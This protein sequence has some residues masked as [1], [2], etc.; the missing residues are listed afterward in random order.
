M[1]TS[2]HNPKRPKGSGTRPLVAFDFDGTLTVRDSFKAFLAWRVSRLRLVSGYLR[3]T[4]AIA[5]YALDHDKERLKTAAVAEFLAGLS[6]ARVEAEAE[7]FAAAVS[8]KFMRPDAL[9]QWEDWG[10]RGALRIIVTAT[11][12][13][14]VAPFARR[15]K[16]DRL[17]GTRLAFDADDRVADVFESRNCRGAEKVARLHEAFGPD[18]RLAAA[19]GDTDGDREMLE[20]ADERGYRIFRGRA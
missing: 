8:D 19:Y 15:L 6:K 7:S 3:L 17:I 1:G 14:V 9:A 11:P 16:A 10:R 4:P 2:S 13:T 5:R 20:M 12:E 18:L